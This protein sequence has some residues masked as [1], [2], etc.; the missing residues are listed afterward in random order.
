MKLTILTRAFPPDV[1]SGRE[2]TI[3]NLWRQACLRDEVTLVS[4]WRKS[5][6]ALPP[7]CWPIAQSSSSRL[8]NYARFFFLSAWYV[9]L[10]R[11][12]VVLSNAIE[13]GPL[14]APN[15]V[16]VHDFN[17]GL[18]DSVRRSNG[19]RRRLVGWRIGRFQAAIA[20]SQATKARILEFGM[21][22]QKVHVIYWG[23]DLDRFRPAG[24]GDVG[25]STAEGTASDQRVRLVY[26]GRIL[27]GKGQH[28]ALEALKKLSP[29][30][31]ER[32]CLVIVGRMDDPAYLDRLQRLA[33]GLP[34]AFHTD[35][36][37]I[38]PFYRSADIVLFPTLMEEGFGLT[39]A[40]ALA[41][42]KPVIF[43]DYPA[44][45]EATAG[46]G[47]PVPIGNA[48]ALAEAIEALIGDPS[49]R[50]TLGKRGYEHAQKCYNWADVYERYRQVL[51]GLTRT[52]REGT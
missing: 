23:V 6:A 10:L 26:P 43:S 29:D 30:V 7:G 8:V 19:L 31:L 39:A 44:V 38:A 14:A 35:V 32:V 41:C 13:V 34:V 42:G 28:I 47:L 40:E 1:I 22:S 21:P 51:I 50:E 17:F 52:R 15:A 9:R 4:G 16:I 49:L 46:I 33:A 11:P 2:T 5:R 3:H 48:D 37:D 20:V 45:R 12:D 25:P 24:R 27:P 36:D 18:A